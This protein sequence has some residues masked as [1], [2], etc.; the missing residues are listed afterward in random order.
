[1]KEFI[2]PYADVETQ[3]MYICMKLTE[4]FKFAVFMLNTSFVY[5]VPKL[6]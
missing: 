5:E 6:V 4:H 2:M 1:M 3:I